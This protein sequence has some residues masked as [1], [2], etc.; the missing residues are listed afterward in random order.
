MV[1]AGQHLQVGVAGDAAQ[2]NDIGY[3][4]GK[5]RSGGVAEIVEAEIF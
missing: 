5:P 4:L 2:F 3:L 1:V